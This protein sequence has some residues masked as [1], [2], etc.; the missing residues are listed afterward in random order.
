MGVFRNQQR[1]DFPLEIHLL[2][3]EFLDFGANEF[4]DIRVGIV[5]HAGSGGVLGKRLAQ[6]RARRNDGA[7]R[8]VLF[9]DLGVVPRRPGHCGIG[10]LFF[11]LREALFEGYEFVQ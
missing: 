4:D 10:E 6:T 9:R 3:F 11:E 8:G 5:E 7:E 2:R 1:A